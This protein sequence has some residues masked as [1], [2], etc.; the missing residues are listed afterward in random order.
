LRRTIKAGSNISYEIMLPNDKKFHKT[1]ATKV[2]EI[3]KSLNINPDNPFA[4]VAQGN[5]TDL[6]DFNPK[7]LSKCIE[8]GL[9]LEPLKNKILESKNKVKKLDKEVKGLTTQK[10]NAMQTLGEINNK[11]K[12]LNEKKKLEKQREKLD[13]ERLWLNRTKLE[14]EI[15]ELKSQIN[16]KNIQ[17]KEKEKEIEQKKAKILELKQKISKNE[18]KIENTN[19]S[20]KDCEIELRLISEKIS[21]FRAE[22]E[23]ISKEKPRL[24][25]LLKSK[26]G[27]LKRYKMDKKEFQKKIDKYKMELE[28]LDARKAELLDQFEQN[29]RLLNRYRKINEEYQS[30]NLEKSKLN[31]EFQKLNM[32]IKNIDNK[33]QEKMLELN[34]VAKE[35]AKY[36]WFL[37]DPEKYSIQA[38]SEKKNRFIKAIQSLKE[39]T[40]KLELK[41]SEL[42]SELEIVKNEIENK[43]FK[44]SEELIKLMKEIKEQDINA[45][46][47]I[48]DI[49]DFRPELTA[50]VFAVLNKYVLSS[51]VAL[52]KGSF[53]KLDNLIK[54]YNVKCNVYQTTNEE[55]KELPP[56]NKNPKEGIYGYLINFIK[57]LIHDEELKKLLLSK[58]RNTVLVKNMLVGYDLIYNAGH[59]GNIVTLMGEIIRKEK[60]VIESRGTKFKRINF[61]P[62]QLKNREIELSQLLRSKRKKLGEL[63]K[64]YSLIENGLKTVDSRISNLQSIQY[65]YTRRNMIINA[66]EALLKQKTELIERKD[67]L[68]A[69]INEKEEELLKLKRN[70]PK[71]MDEIDNFNREFKSKMQDIDNKI[72]KIKSVI[73]SNRKSLNNTDFQIEKITAEIDEYKKRLAEINEKLN[74]SSS[75]VKECVNKNSKLRDQIAE[76]NNKLN[77]LYEENK[78]YGANIENINDEIV[79]I[80]KLINR[81]DLKIEQIYLN[82]VNK[83]QQLKDIKIKFEELGENYI[84]R[85]LVEIENDYKLILEKLREYYDVTDEILTEKQKLEA[86]IEKINE[87]KQELIKEL[88]ECILA[89]KKWENEF[90]SK[91]KTGIKIIEEYINASFRRLNMAKSARIEIMGEIENLSAKI[92]VKLNNQEERSIDVLSGGEKSILQLSIILSLQELNPTPLCIFDE[93]QMFLDLKNSQEINKLIKYTTNKGI[94]FII[95]TPDQTKIALEYADAIIG[96]A[97]NKE[98]DDDLKSK[99]N[100]INKLDIKKEEQKG[101]SKLIMDKDGVSTVINF[102]VQY[103]INKIKELEQKHQIKN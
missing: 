16:N 69:E 81:I 5:I 62:M 83:E 43:G 103:Y 98:D 68:L 27:E 34:Q 99:D 91:L 56:I 18:E 60:Y 89:Q 49:I 22:E 80:N 82:L 10:E 75:F 17:K 63:N 35:L 48:I 29:N 45:I 74:S 100:N 2:R 84:P 97:K 3:V 59:K 31:I 58:C 32:E 20:I 50:A 9:G 78:N 4:F 93:C 37:K 19:Q 21:K 85:S 30:I 7:D 87:K 23:E 28:D 65:N 39:N 71:N 24:E 64:K 101:E 1:Y 51:F 13:K 14:N 73:E 102:P 11:I 86:N 25:S 12:R 96:I 40:K 55:I 26:K 94:Q 47:P 52:D 76:L 66:K 70:L 6:K 38:L 42:E 53:L 46:G 54:K 61:N 44:K 36:N 57:P 41:I 92:F 15:K 33:V 88:N 90:F 95:L 72:N 67:K 79:N 77:Q 8:L